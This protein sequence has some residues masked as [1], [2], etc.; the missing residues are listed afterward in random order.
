M[1]KQIILSFYALAA[2][3]FTLGCVTPLK[4]PFQG[5]QPANRVSI[6]A[7]NVEN[8]FDTVHDEGKDDYTFLP[9]KE[10]RKSPDVK[11]FCAT[12]SRGRKSECYNLDWSPKVLKTKFEALNGAVFQ[13]YGKGPDILMLEEIE[14]IKVL[15]QWNESG[16]KQAG[17][18]TVELIEGPDKRG[19]D[20]ALLSRFPVEG[21]SQL[22]TIEW[23]KALDQ[24]PFPTRGILEVPLRLPSGHIIHVFVV[25][26]PSQ[27]SPT[28]FREDAVNNIKNLVSKVPVDRFWVVGGDWNITAEEDEQ[29]G[30]IS[31]TLS[32]FGLVS[33]IYGCKECRGTYNYRKD[34]NFLDILLFSKNL[35]QE[36]SP[37]KLVADSITVPQWGP[38][39]AK[40]SGR[41]YRFDPEKGEGIS[42]HFPIYG[43]IEFLLPTA[44]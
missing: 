23:E 36:N 21:K 1:K 3:V 44:K 32:E 26:F 7:F 37:L 20:V 2:L 6:M 27:A 9:L 28:V 22:H 39:Q 33:H 40:R 15:K 16:L 17:Y 43:E 5:E 34:W 25:H 8:L 4:N 18:Q 12:Q 35:S 41:P 10:K 19:I 30:L 13:V 29:T 31:K 14:N 24:D 38:K 11:A 42:D